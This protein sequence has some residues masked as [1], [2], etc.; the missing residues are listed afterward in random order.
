MRVVRS[1]T[2]IRAGEEV[3]I[4]YISEES[5]LAPKEIRRQLLQD[6]KEFFCMCTRCSAEEDDTRVFPCYRCPGKVLARVDGGQCDV[7]A[8]PL[9]PALL[10]TEKD[11]LNDLDYIDNVLDNGFRVDV[12][13]KLL[14]LRPVHPSHY[15]T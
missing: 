2:C 14:A 12:T 4:N 8:K 1:L 13:S 6:Q 5:L 11:L 10:R 7:C 9:D 15:L 3:C